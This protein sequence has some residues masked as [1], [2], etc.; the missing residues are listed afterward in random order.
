LDVLEGTQ[1]AYSRAL[2]YWNKAAN[3]GDL[4]ALVRVADYYYYGL[5]VEQEHREAA[6]LYM[7]AESGLHAQAAFNLGYLYEHGLG[8][9]QVR[10]GTVEGKTLIYLFIYFLR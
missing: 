1:I 4:S 10:Q 6:D 8:V 5:G 7:V 9:P 3:Q 2:G